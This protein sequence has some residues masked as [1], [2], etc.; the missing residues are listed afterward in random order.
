MKKRVLSMLM[1]LALCLSLLPATALAAAP[2]EQFSGLTPGRTY[3][4]DLSGA[5]IPGEKNGNLPDD[6]LHWVPFTY[7]GAV[8]AYVLKAASS[9]VKNASEQAASTN[10]PNGQY[11]YTYDHS[12]FVADYAVTHTVSWDDL[13]TASLIFGKN[14][15]SGGV[16]YTLRAPSAGSSDDGAS[17]GAPA[18]NEW[19]MI[20]AKNSVDIKNW[21]NMYSWGQDTADLVDQYDSSFRPNRGH[22]SAR[23]WDC[24]DATIQF[25]V[26][27]FRPVLEI[28]NPDTLGPDSLTTV[29]LDLNG[30]SIGSIT[31]TVNL[32][33]KSDFNLALPGGKDVTRPTGNTGAYFKWQDSNGNFYEP[34]E[35][36]PANVTR[37]TALWAPPEQL[38]GLTT[39][40]T[41]W[42][43]LS[44]AG[45]PGNKNGSLP[46]STLHYVPFTYTGT[47]EA[48]KL[49]SATATT[50]EYAQREKYPHSL[51]VADYVVTNDVSWNTLNEKNLIF[52]KSYTSG[53]V[54]YNL[55]A[56]SA[57]SNSTGS[58]DSQRGVPQSN[59]WDTILDKDNGYIQNWNEMFSWGQDTF[60]GDASSRAIRGCKSARI[61][62]YNFATSQNA[63]RGF[64]PVLEVLNPGTLGPDSLT[65]VTLDLNGGHVGRDAT[66][67]TVNLAVKSSGTYTAPSSDGLTRPDGDTGS[68]FVWLG[69]NGKLYAPGAS[70]PADVTKLT[71]Q[72]TLSEQFSLTPGGRYYFD[73]SGEKIPGT[74]NGNLPDSALHYVPFTYA[75]TI[76]AYKLMPAMATTEEY[77]QKKKYA[78][79]LF[80]ADYAV[81]HTVSWDDLNSAGLIF[82]KG[83]VAGGVD[84]TLRAPSAGSNSTG[85]GDSERIVPQSN[86]WDTMLNKDDEYIQNWN[87][88]FSWGQ[89]TFSGD[90][91][92]RARRGYRS[93]R[94]GD[95]L[96]ATDQY[97]DVG[98][99]PVL[100]VLNP[101]TLG[102]DGLKVVTLDLG[103]GKLG[104]SSED[105]HIIVK[106]GSE[107]AAPASDGL[108]RPDGDTGSYFVWL[109]S[110]GKL[111]APGV[112]VPADVTKLTA[113]FALSEQFSLTP[114]GRYYFDLSGE[115]IPGTANGSL[116]DSTL[117]Y[118]PFTYAGTIEAYK[119][120]S[121]TATTEE[122][123]QREKYPHSLF[124]ADYNVT[125]TVSW[126]DLNTK[127]LIFG[128][129]YASGGVSYTLRAPSVGSKYT[130]S[131]DSERGTPQ[132]NEWDKILDKDS[133][134]INWPDM[135]SWGQDTATTNES[136]RA[137]RGCYSARGYVWNPSSSRSASF[138]FRPVL[139][140]LNPGTLGPDSLTTVT[141]DLNGGHVGRDATAVTVNLAVKSS[142]TYTAPSSD[143]LTRP[144]GNDGAYFKWQ[145]S[146]GN[147]YKPGEQVPA[148][149]TRL[150]ARWEK[151]VPTATAND[152]TVTYTGSAVPDSA[153]T[154]IASVAGS[155]RFKNAAPVNVADSSDSVTVVFTPADTDTYETVEKT[156]KV[157]IN[158]ATPTGAPAYTAI[159]SDGKTLADAALT[160]GTIT[161]AGGSI[162]WDVAADTAVTANTAYNW[163]YTPTNT[164]NYNH[165]TGSI[166]P[167]VVSYSGGGSSGSSNTTTKTEKNPD[168]STTTTVTDKK[169]GTVTE[170]TKNTDGSTTVVETKKDGTVTETNKAADGTTGT[171]VTDK[172]GDVAEVKASV[173]SAAAE[174]AAKTGGAVTLPV[175]VPAVKTTGDAP[176]VEVSVPKNSGSVKVEIPVGKVTPGTVAVIVNADGTEEIVK[177]SLPTADGIQLTVNGGATV[178]IVDNSKDFADTRN[179]WAK[180]AIDF[181]SARGLVNGMNAVSYAPDASTTRAQLWTI[182]ARQNDADLTGGATWFENAQNWA[183]E[184]GI[185]DGTNPNGTI[186]RAQMVTMLWRAAGSPAPK[187][188]TR[189]FS[190]IMDDSYYADAVAW[191]I[192]N[193][194]TAGVGGDRFDPNS[195]CTR[196][197]IATF[198]HRLYLSR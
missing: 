179:H 129:N 173:S 111:Y 8:D 78:H 5:G 3:W 139:E 101:D 119:L 71:A 120:T 94:Y 58:G 197:Q 87:E 136:H 130:G 73:L 182:L 170:T 174:E 44:G 52:G 157:T 189:R 144:T 17:G 47:I 79:S 20:L 178:K 134:Y 77:A 48:Y 37:L 80:V 88:M 138:G 99:R 117:H 35:P 108:T 85:S 33:V 124:V 126:N 56:P 156:I 31:G 41:Y 32:A 196:G 148:N 57:G 180:D 14:Y 49:T 90:A 149:V 169:T 95:Y 27:G 97:M 38:S 127:S 190:D 171:V 125:H 55:R 92:Y 141:L 69:S 36:V 63:G 98:F 6:S 59:E 61:W 194:I 112:S 143:G 172:N 152:I 42:F 102:S 12:L 198:L 142:G 161:P 153:I 103:G 145:D 84:Y 29:T 184:K 132:S 110:N 28:L 46:D 133:G 24:S 7:A 60:S 162:A 89:D 96:T 18:S 68:Y 74:A 100:E 158:K 34:G 1:A 116:P 118:V 75:G 135:Y 175:E 82:G 167:Y 128:K 9:G 186:N 193:G 187:A 53:G 177:N 113:Q 192:E 183:K 4:F 155:W 114:G 165:L 25:A 181:V 70:V 109:G 159:T 91:S 26:V 62:T 40:G 43:D 154:G 64:R 150:T 137:L 121:A 185:S 86:E 2:E 168:G 146:N 10:D 163:T 93:A 107:F 11:G 72:F 176:A 19:D 66:A 164:D 140:V 195:T 16:D 122:Y 104:N 39:G 67:V 188:T 106:T 83:Y 45:I 105:I 13:N 151:D 50:E 21:N 51:F 54:D 160:V 147:R 76:E 30:G 191:A 123:A 166:T 81:T 131:D 115:K 65:T 23:H 22:G 15:T